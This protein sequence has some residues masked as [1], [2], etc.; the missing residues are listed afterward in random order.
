MIEPL[1]GLDDQDDRRSVHSVAS[2]V[3]TT[4]SL[5]SRL[6]AL[7]VDFG[8]K[9]REAEEENKEPACETLAEDSAGE[10]E[11][12]EQP[13]ASEAAASLH[14]SHAAS[15]RER[16]PPLFVCSRLFERRGQPPLRL[17][18]L[19]M[20]QVEDFRQHGYV[21]LDGLIPRDAAARIKA[22]VLRQHARGERV[23]RGTFV[24][25]CVEC[26]LLPA[27]GEDAYALQGHGKCTPTVF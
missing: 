5:A 13:S 11:D 16:E 23:G 6:A 19:S 1:I 25:V 27:A 24:Q 15:M 21:V 7:N 9:L 26:P 4:T 18:R 14:G 20:M 2:T 17:Q 10:Q 8:D 22:E 3:A 12:P